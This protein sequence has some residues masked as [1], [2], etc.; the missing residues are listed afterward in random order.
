M[1]AAEDPDQVGQQGSVHFVGF[2]VVTGLTAESGMAH[3]G[4]QD[5]R[6]VEAEDPGQVGQQGP[7]QPTQARR[8]LARPFVS[9]ASSR[10][11]AGHCGRRGPLARCSE[12]RNVLGRSACQR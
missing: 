10:R 12:N 11:T 5:R 2:A 9:Y 4:T 7:V 1:V 6:M 3:A 8:V